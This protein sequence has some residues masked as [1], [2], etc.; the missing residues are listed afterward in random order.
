VHEEPDIVLG[1]AIIESSR[2]RLRTHLSLTTHCSI[3]HVYWVCGG[4]SC[5]AGRRSNYETGV[6]AYSF[7]PQSRA[8]AVPREAGSP[9]LVVPTGSLKP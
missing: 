8:G 1:G 6:P 5:Y 2:S 4:I 7:E 3:P 9:A